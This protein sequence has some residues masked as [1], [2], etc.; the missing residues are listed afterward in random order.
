MIDI[1]ADGRH[2]Q[3]MHVDGGTVAQV[4]LYPPSFAAPT[5][6]VATRAR[7]ERLRRRSQSAVQ[8]LR[9]SATRGPAPISRPST[10]AR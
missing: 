4:V 3:E 8:P 7:S 1:E 10:A 5:S 2:F 9:A 6:L